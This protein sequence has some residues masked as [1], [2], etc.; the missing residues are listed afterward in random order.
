[1]L[2]LACLAQPAQAEPDKRAGCGVVNTAQGPVLR[3]VAGCK[4]AELA[5]AMTAATRLTRDPVPSAQA[6]RSGRVRITELDPTHPLNRLSQAN[7]MGP[8]P[9]S[10]SG[11]LGVESGR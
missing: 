8:A 9:R 7:S 11:W 1:M 5:Q 10:G 2:L 6:R 3:I 4:P